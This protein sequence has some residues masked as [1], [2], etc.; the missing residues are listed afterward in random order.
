[1]FRAFLAHPRELL[2]CLVSRYG[3]REYGRALWCLVW[4][5][6]PWHC[7]SV[8]LQLYLKVMLAATAMGENYHHC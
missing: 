8:N 4:S 3:K 7:L 6:F 5:V 2:Y 1:M